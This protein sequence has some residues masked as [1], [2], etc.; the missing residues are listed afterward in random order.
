MRTVVDDKLVNKS[1]PLFNF[2]NYLHYFRQC[3]DVARRSLSV[4]TAKF[5]CRVGGQ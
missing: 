3:S 2:A 1:V 5:V 4:G